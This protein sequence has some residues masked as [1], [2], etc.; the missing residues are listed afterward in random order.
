MLVGM[1]VAFWWHYLMSPVRRSLDTRWVVSHSPQHYWDQVQAAIRRGTWHHEVGFAVGYY[2]D[3][4]WAEWIMTRVRAGENM[5]CSA[6]LNHSATSMQ[7]ITNQ[8]AGESADGW[9]AWWGANRHKSQIDW[10]ADGFCQRGVEVTFP[11]TE[12]QIEEL[13]GLLGNPD[14]Q[15]VP[16]YVKYNAFRCLRESKFEPVEYLLTRG[17]MPTRREAGLRQYEQYLDRFPRAGSAGILPLEPLDDDRYQLPALLLPE[18][19]IAVQAAMWVPFV[20]GMC[21]VGWALRP[22]RTAN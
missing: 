10:I 18:T 7:Y 8:D 9:L 22:R 16:D 12:R 3:K 15:A 5:G 1:A 20:V 4:S 19:Q 17:E 14:A 13:L 2:G 6:R 21:L 11:P